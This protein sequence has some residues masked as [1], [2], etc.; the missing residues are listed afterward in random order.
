MQAHDS[1]TFGQ[2]LPTRA[3]AEREPLST[4]GIP[5]HPSEF[6]RTSKSIHYKSL[7]SEPPIFHDPKSSSNYVSPL[8]FCG[9]SVVPASPGQLPISSLWGA[10]ASKYPSHDR[11]ISQFHSFFDAA[12]FPAT[13]SQT[14]VSSLLY[15]SVPNSPPHSEISCC[16]ST[17]GLTSQ[18]RR[19]G[20]PRKQPPKV[21]Q[22]SIAVASERQLCQPSQETQDSASELEMGGT[23]LPTE[24]ADLA[25]QMPQLHPLGQDPV[26]GFEQPQAQVYHLSEWA[27][28]YSSD[29]TSQILKNDIPNT[30]FAESLKNIESVIRGL[31]KDVERGRV[32]KR[33]HN[34]MVA[35]YRSRHKVLKQTLSKYRDIG[36]SAKE[37]KRHMEAWKAFEAQYY[38]EYFGTSLECPKPWKS[39]V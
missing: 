24:C 26:S 9:H 19:R 39:V 29:R 1:S 23:P 30:T 16:I 4:N 20:R 37:Q 10:E 31:K 18:S 12:P 3:P 32:E 21:E 6:F 15:N 38:Q 11:D 27:Q 34:A 7:P 14:S 13:H 17:D 5:T 8:A 35:R 33:E 22:I 25:Y 2:L 28:N 36:K